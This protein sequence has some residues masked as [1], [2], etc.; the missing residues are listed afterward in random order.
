MR[1]GLDSEANFACALDF[2]SEGTLS[3]VYDNL[4]HLPFSIR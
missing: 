4:V 3:S 1:T 2:A